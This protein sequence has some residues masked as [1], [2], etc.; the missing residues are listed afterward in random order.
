VLDAIGDLSLFGLPVIGH[1]SAYK[2]G[3]GLNQALVA[4][5]LGDP[6]SHRVV[7]VSGEK[8]LEPLRVQLPKLAPA[9]HFS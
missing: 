4:K 6:S 1:F 2:S 7:R 5:V 3:H 8:A 9:S